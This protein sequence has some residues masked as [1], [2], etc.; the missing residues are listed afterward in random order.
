MWRI[1]QNT[2]ICNSKHNINV[3]TIGVIIY[4]D[5]TNKKTR[6]KISR[7]IMHKAIRAEFIVLFF[8]FLVGLGLLFSFGSHYTPE[9]RHQ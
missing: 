7:Y 9:V 8:F 6:E 5:N 4:I 2:Y 1:S 3:K